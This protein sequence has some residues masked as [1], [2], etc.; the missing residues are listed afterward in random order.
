MDGNNDSLFPLTIQ[1]LRFGRNLFNL[2]WTRV[3]GAYP[4]NQVRRQQSSYR[5]FYQPQK[6]GQGLGSQGF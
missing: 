6:Q 1:I 3:C 5:D 2:W 4:E